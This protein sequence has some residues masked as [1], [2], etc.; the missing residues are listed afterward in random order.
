MKNN[1]NI[2]SS[3]TCILVSV[4]IVML[5]LRF[6]KDF[7]TMKPTPVEVESL[8]DE[9]IFEVPYKL[10]CVPGPQKTAGAYTRNLTP[11][12]YCGMQKVVADKSDYKIVGGIGG[13]LLD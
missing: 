8:N 9:S 12:G 3:L 10:E 13:S 2:Y 6:Q 7:Y 1:N 11:G 4:A 5:V